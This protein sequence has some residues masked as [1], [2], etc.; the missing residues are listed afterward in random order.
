MGLLDGF[1]SDDP[2]QQAQLALAMGLLSGGGGKGVGGFARDLGRAGI[3]AQSAYNQASLLK[4]KRAEEEQQRKFREMQMGEMQRKLS[5]A[6]TFREVLG[7]Y[8]APSPYEDAK[9][10]MPSLAPTVANQQ[11]LESKV[12]SAPS[13]GKASEY[14]RLMGIAKDLEKRGLV[15][16]AQQYYDKATKA[17]PEL[18]D[19]KTLT[20]DGQ[21]VTVNF[22]KDGTQEVV[23]FG[24]DKEKLHFADNGQFSGIGLDPFSGGVISG[25]VRKEQSP[26]SIASNALTRRGQ[27]L[28]D[29]RSRDANAITSGNK[30]L[31]L[32]QGIRKEFAS[33]PEVKKYKEVIPVVESA[34]NAP[35]TPAGDFALIYGVGKALDPES[36]VREGEMNM[37]M[38]AGSPAQRVQG[39][40]NH[41]RGKGRITPQMRQE[42]MQILDQRA[43]EYASQYEAQKATYSGIAEKAGVGLDQVFTDI[44]SGSVKPSSKQV[45]IGSK[46]L[47]ARRAP[48]GKYYVKSGDRYYEVTE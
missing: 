30:Q 47:E 43:G 24:P 13:S 36:V 9:A 41:L 48:D 21:R 16:Y 10:S 6:N 29:A 40:L 45:T 4:D 3:G 14:T 33:L 22:Y 31:D 26:D 39:Y 11:T 25:G 46:K 15:D 19:T 1:F 17:M 37:V 2:R 20:K 28:T 38:K 35:D 18:K 12:A 34:R 44:P 42:L 23:P 32:A 5:D 7:G 27:D 8:Q